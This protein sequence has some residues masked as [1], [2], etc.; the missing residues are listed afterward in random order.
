MSYGGWSGPQLGG[1]A[2]GMGLGLVTRDAVGVGVGAG[3]ATG[4]GDG[5]VKE[6][7]TR[8]RPERALAAAMRLIAAK[9]DAASNNALANPMALP[10]PGGGHRDPVTSGAGGAG[11]DRGTALASVDSAGNVYADYAKV[12]AMTHDAVEAALQE[13]PEETDADAA[14]PMAAFQ[15]AFQTR[16]MREQLKEQVRTEVQN[17][18]KAEVRQLRRKFLLAAEAMK[19]KKP[20]Q[21]G[22]LLQA[23]FLAAHDKSRG[24]MGASNTAANAQKMSLLTAP[25]PYDE[26]LFGVTNI[27]LHQTKNNTR[28]MQQILEYLLGYSSVV[29][30]EDLEEI[31]AGS[32]GL[33]VSRGKSM[34]ELALKYAQ[35]LDKTLPERHKG[36]IRS[37]IRRS[38]EEHTRHVRMG[39]TA[40]DNYNERPHETCGDVNAFNRDAWL[41][42][43]FPD[44]AWPVPRNRNALAGPNGGALTGGDP[45][46]PL[47]A[48][49]SAAAI[50]A[51]TGD[52]ERVHVNR[53]GVA[54]AVRGGGAFGLGGS[55][56][57]PGTVTAAGQRGWAS[58]EA[59]SQAAKPIH[60]PPS[61][62]MMGQ[63]SGPNVGG[64][65]GGRAAGYGPVMVPGAGMVPTGQQ[66][67]AMGLHNP[68]M[69]GGAGGMGMTQ[70]M[71]QQ[72][73][74]QQPGG[75]T[76]MMHGGGGFGAGGGGFGAMPGLG[77]QNSMMN[78]QQ[79]QAMLY[80]GGGPTGGGGGGGGGYAAQ[81]HQPGMGGGGGYM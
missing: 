36:V 28:V 70:Q 47:D 2:G 79:Q 12:E 78:P 38:A 4:V 33:Q 3:S 76:M 40:E 51:A 69:M 80:G 57:E 14:N 77:G 55:V 63:M 9:A 48:T 23:A 25:D 39:Q 6:I 49:A 27:A 31:E 73:Q 1:T 41:K 43:M 50:A 13:I 42:E 54:G 18:A 32:Q 67:P 60:A 56:A 46:D 34:R 17:K 8:S 74:R 44:A 62:P 11:G 53:R 45:G 16:V 22:A 35:H 29:D 61:N 21:K 19:P 59:A 71:Q 30:P 37:M 81:Q 58:M 10:A 7:D 24:G 15:A 52:D 65:A 5:A 64:V 75:G 68:T 66:A 20:Q 26:S 72:M